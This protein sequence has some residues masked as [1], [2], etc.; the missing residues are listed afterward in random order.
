MAQVPVM[1]VEVELTCKKCTRKERVDVPIACDVS[2]EVK[3]GALAC[4]FIGDVKQYLKEC[5]ECGS[6]QF[7]VEQK[8]I[9]MG[10]GA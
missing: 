3:G 1:M 2:T 9:R 7:K 8:K 4:S 5:K 6:K 10:T